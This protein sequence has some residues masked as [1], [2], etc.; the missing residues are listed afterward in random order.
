[1]KKSKENVI[2]SIILRCKRLFPDFI[3][4]NML[5]RF[6]NNDESFPLTGSG[7]RSIQHLQQMGLDNTFRI[8]NGN[9]IKNEIDIYQSELD[10]DQN[11]IKK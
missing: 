8:I 3:Y 4:K 7:K 11:R 2:K 6:I 5:I 10:N 1:M 9:L